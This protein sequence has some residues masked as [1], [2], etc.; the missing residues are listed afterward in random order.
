MESSEEQ[1]THVSGRRNTGY[2]SANEEGDLEIVTPTRYV[3]LNSP[4][5]LSD[6][7]ESLG[8][9]LSLSGGRRGQLAKPMN[10]PPGPV[11][12]GTMDG[13]MD[14]GTMVGTLAGTTS[15]QWDNTLQH[16]DD[17]WS[18]ARGTSR[19]TMDRTRRTVSFMDR[20]ENNTICGSASH[21]EEGRGL[22][23]DSGIE[24]MRRESYREKKW[25]P[26]LKLGTYDGTT[27][28]ETFLAK[29]ENCADYYV[30][31]ERD[32]Q[33]HLR[34]SLEKVAGNVLWDAGVQ[35]S[36]AD[37]IQLLRNRFGSQGQAERFRTELRARLHK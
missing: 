14:D 25:T 32:R 20:E 27:P 22:L 13:T 17:S 24:E 11:Q 29:F 34:A 12:V 31:I 36:S 16:P 26:T 5:E 19:S 10:K 33:C 8:R 30:G 21:L 37:L 4:G 35:S 2:L 7:A 18:G 15:D 1:R 6:R 9:G 28:L 23:L 3:G